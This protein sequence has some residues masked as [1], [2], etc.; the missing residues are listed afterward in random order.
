MVYGD[1]RLFNVA[2]VVPDFTTLKPWAEGQG[3][4]APS[5]EKLIEDPKVKEQMKSEVEKF[6]AEFKGF[7]EI[8]KIALLPE[9]FTTENGMLT[10]S[11]K[12][13]RRV[14]TQKYGDKIESLYEGAK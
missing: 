7:E 4:S 13:K 5:D 3:I 14:V 8:K 10:P 2:L 1:N 12:V 11:M 6:T 9:D